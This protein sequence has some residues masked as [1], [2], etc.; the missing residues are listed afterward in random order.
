V[1]ES[2]FHVSVED[3]VDM[4]ANSNWRNARLYGGN[5]WQH[6]GVQIIDLVTALRT[7]NNGAAEQ[8]I[9]AIRAARHNTGRVSDKLARLEAAARKS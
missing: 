6:I 3:F 9:S 8:L 7:G 1:F 5:A 4:F 2:H